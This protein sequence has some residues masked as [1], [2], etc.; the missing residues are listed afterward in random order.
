MPEGDTI[1]RLA[2]RLRPV[3]IGQQ[4]AGIQST[5]TQIRERHLVG[6]YVEEV[7]TR[8]KHLLMSFSSGLTL[9]THLRMN[10]A[11]QVYER[12]PNWRAPTMGLKIALLTN[13]HACVCVAAPLVRLLR[14]ER[15]PLDPMLSALGPDLLAEGFSE[16][17]A[18]AR[19]A[20]QG[21]RTIAEALLDQSLLAGIGN[22]LKSE[23]L[24]LQGVHPQTQVAAL[25]L[26]EVGKIVHEAAVVMEKVVTPGRDRQFAL[27]G[28]VTRLTSQSMNGRGGEL[29]V[30]GRER[31]PCYRCG[32]EIKLTTFGKDARVTYHCPHCQPARAH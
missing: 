10:G 25:S 15:L 9:H 24:F 28:R 30:Y 20:T 16:E 5:V 4:I 13:Q 1:F 18:T 32:S 22:V 8:G 17:E 27:P 14:T 3:L 21:E 12:R 2:A 29:W 26:A 23:V 11:W 7:S 19:L 6:S 31:E